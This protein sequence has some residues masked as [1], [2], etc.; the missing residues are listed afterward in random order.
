MPVFQRLARVQ[1]PRHRLEQIIWPLVALIP[2]VSAVLQALTGYTE[3][4]IHDAAF[5]GLVV[6][7]FV[8]NR[9]RPALGT[10]LFLMLLPLFLIWM[11]RSPGLGP[12]FI[13][14]FTGYSG[15]LMLPIALS[16]VWFGFTG[17]IVFSLYTLALGTVVFPL[18]L[19]QQL[20]VVWSMLMQLAAGSLVAWLLDFTDKTF[21]MLQRGA[22]VD[23][24]TGLGNRRA[25]DDALAEAWEADSA[26]MSLALVDID[27][28]KLVNDQMGHD[29]GDRLIRRFAQA[30]ARHLENGQQAFRLGGDEFV[31]LCS[32]DRG[33]TLSPALARAILQVRGSGFPQAAASMGLASGTEVRGPREL[34]HLADVRMYEVKRSKLRTDSRSFEGGTRPSR[35]ILKLN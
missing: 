2:L 7:A 29:A 28:L 10:M 27:G 4:F 14:D 25:F 17:V 33:Q 15:I 3:N 30:V 31:V 23:G 35:E 20:G 5:L 22:L 34:L 1:T 8:L 32:R 11:A 18:P 13:G 21:A 26:G 24:L 12:L 19:D 6:C 9:C 16:A